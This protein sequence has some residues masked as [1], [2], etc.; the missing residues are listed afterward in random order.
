VG[1]YGLSFFTNARFEDRKRKQA[2]LEK[3]SDFKQRLDLDVA[4]EAKKMVESG[5][6]RGPYEIKRI[7][8]PKGE[9]KTSSPGDQAYENGVSCEEGTGRPQSWKLAFEH[10]NKA[11]KEGHNGAALRLALIHLHGYSTAK[12]DPGKAFQLAEQAHKAGVKGASA[13]VG[14]LYRHGHGVPANRETA[15]KYFEK[16][17]DDVFG[18]SY[19]AEY[20]RN[21]T[22]G[23][24]KDE[25]KAA[26]L[27]QRS[28][29]ELERM[30]EAGNSRAQNRLAFCLHNGFMAAKD[31]T[32]AVELWSLAAHQ[33]LAAAQCSLGYCY[34]MAKGCGKDT[35]R[36][37]NWYGKA[38]EQG[39]PQAQY[40]LGLYWRDRDAPK[41]FSFL[42]Q[43]AERGDPGAQNALG[44]CYETGDGVAEDKQKA[45]GLYTKAA[46]AGNMDAQYNLGL[47]YLSG[48]CGI[49]EDKDK[50]KE[51]FQLAAKQGQP[52]AADKIKKM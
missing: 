20:A 15:V 52:Q 19:Y 39:D 2:H 25:K 1:T 43:A 34:Q 7:S 6:G 37:L 28:N 47:V 23:A 18:Q 4:E 46:E 10:Y 38:A 49:A 33:G 31:F 30:A 41:A 40:N 22:A 24:T 26:E 8:R 29:R 42:M 45:M 12:V 32:R 50:A 48:K 3:A 35:E 51:L 36:S 9:E 44:R 27:F 14:A 13:L 5:V 11:L 16:D 17:L 21:G